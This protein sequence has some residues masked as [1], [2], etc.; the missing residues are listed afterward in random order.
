M[1][2]F[3]KY[4]EIVNK[5]AKK[6]KTS[7]DHANNA[8]IKAQQKGINPLKW[9]KHLAMLQT[10]VQILA[11]YDGDYEKNSNYAKKH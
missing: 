3:S 10:F 9:Q 2:T 6:L 11:H 1:I 8:L 4:S 5:V 7:K